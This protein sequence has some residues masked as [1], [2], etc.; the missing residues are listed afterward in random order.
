MNKDML[1]TL[2]IWDMQ[3][4]NY[5]KEIIKTRIEFIKKLIN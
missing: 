4:V 5:G 2:D 1:D 3:L